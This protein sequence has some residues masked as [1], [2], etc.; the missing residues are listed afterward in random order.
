M[1]ESDS[2]IAPEVKLCLKSF[3][4]LREAQAE[5]PQARDDRSLQAT[6]TDLIGRFRV[7]SGNI[8]AHQTGKSSLDYRLRDASYI[9]SRVVRLLRDLN[10]QVLD[11]TSFSLMR[12]TRCEFH[13]TTSRPMSFFYQALHHTHRSCH[14]HL[15]AVTT[16]GLIFALCQ[17]PPR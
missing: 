12:K 1:A 2:T 10:S 3:N 17:R 15:A 11:G 7:W 16:Y 14:F 13:P 5:S 6:I 9:K 8:G 4:A